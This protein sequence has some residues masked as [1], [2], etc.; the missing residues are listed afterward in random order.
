MKSHHL[1]FSTEHFGMGLTVVFFFNK[2]QF[3]TQCIS[4]LYPVQSYPY[5]QVRRDMG[6]LSQRDG[7]ELGK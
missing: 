6:L 3:S 5:R 2:G 1:W 7:A 4:H